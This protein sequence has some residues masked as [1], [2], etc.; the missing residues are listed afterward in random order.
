MSW[1]RHNSTTH[2]DLS[3]LMDLRKL[4]MNT[5]A[6][7]GNADIVGRLGGTVDVSV[8]GQQLA[9]QLNN[10]DV[11]NLV[12][13]L[14]VTT[15]VKWLERVLFALAPALAEQK[16]FDLALDITEQ[17]K[18]LAGA[19]I[20]LHA[21]VLRVYLQKR[22]SQAALAEF[23]AML[24]LAA[25]TAIDPDADELIVSSRA[26]VSFSRGE[27]GQSIHEF[28]RAQSVIETKTAQLAAT[29]A[30][31]G[32]NFACAAAF[33]VMSKAVAVTVMVAAM[34]A[35]AAAGEALSLSAAASAAV[36]A[37]AAIMAV[38][39]VAASAA[40]AA[41]AAGKAA[42]AVAPKVDVA[43][44]LAVA[45]KRAAAAAAA[46]AS[47]V[48]R[49]AAV[50]AGFE[51]ELVWQQASQMMCAAAAVARVASSTA[52]AAAAEATA[53]AKAA[54]LLA[55]FVHTAARQ[56]QHELSEAARKALAAENRR[57]NLMARTR[58][59]RHRH[60][61]ILRFKAERKRES[62]LIQLAKFDYPIVLRLKVQ[63]FTA[64]LPILCRALSN[65]NWQLQR[66]AH[67]VDCSTFSPKIPEGKLEHSERWDDIHVRRGTT[68]LSQ[69]EVRMLGVHRTQ[70]HFAQ[71]AVETD[72]DKMAML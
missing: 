42:A 66:T 24:S 9:G 68:R 51:A 6:A 27:Y 70:A 49:D 69:S 20:R 28:E 2:A 55:N 7:K 53:L 54:S 25:L 11:S 62:E 8:L 10:S 14:D 50:T 72:L 64:R 71:K 22:D 12:A 65:L 61:L 19:S 40:V 4:L 44:Q 48:A 26:L 36:A 33:D 39:E 43:W 38:T 31:E 67:D 17:L 34:T 5:I 46:T 16:Q 37:S 1:E 23:N 32:A 30:R 15:A 45:M 21:L 58:S 59:K 52:H 18:R 35:S 57:E 63:Q 29:A 47:L 3:F 41:M 13:Q 56:H 60:T